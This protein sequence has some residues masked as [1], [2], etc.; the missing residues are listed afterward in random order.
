MMTLRSSGGKGWGLGFG[1]G[2][3]VVIA[4]VFHSVSE[5]LGSF[6]LDGDDDLD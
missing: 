5:C 6:S 2:W 1:G 3:W 4:E